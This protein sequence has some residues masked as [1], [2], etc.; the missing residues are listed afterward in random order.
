MRGE[1][2]RGVLLPWKGFWLDLGV[3]W[4]SRLFFKVYTASLWMHAFATR[5]LEHVGLQ[6]RRT[7][8]RIGSRGEEECLMCVVAARK[9][10]VFILQKRASGGEESLVAD[11]ISWLEIR[12]TTRYWRENGR[13]ISKSMLTITWLMDNK[14]KI[15]SP[16]NCQIRPITTAMECTHV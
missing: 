13:R 10:W 6:L 11:W 3:N 15:F 16:K 9:F 7:I 8:E 4:S 5:R 2:C 1:L 14:L 12:V